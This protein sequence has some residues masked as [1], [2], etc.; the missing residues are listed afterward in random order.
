MT[1]SKMMSSRLAPVPFMLA[2]NLNPGRASTAAGYDRKLVDISP[3]TMV[4]ICGK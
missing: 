4:N 1:S 3:L 2:Q